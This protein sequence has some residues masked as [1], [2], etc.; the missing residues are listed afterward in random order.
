MV[1]MNRTRDKKVPVH[2]LTGFLGSGKTSLINRLFQAGM[3]DD[4]AVIINE[5]G[6]IGFDSDFIEGNDQEIFEVSGGCLCC[7]AKEG[8]VDAVED[9]LSKGAR[10]V[11]IETSGLAEIAPLLFLLSESD[12]IGEKIRIANV[13]TMIDAVSAEAAIEDFSEA[14]NQVALAD[15][16]VF[17]KLQDVDPSQRG[18]LSARLHSMILARN[19]VAKIDDLQTLIATFWNDEDRFQTTP[20]TSHA[21]PHA[22]HQASLL[23]VTL[24]SRETADIE[25]LEGFLRHLLDRFGNRI[26]RLKGVAELEKGAGV[27]AVHAVSGHAAKFE[28]LVQNNTTGV[29]IVVFYREIRRKEISDLFAAFLDY[30]QTDTPDRDGIV[31]NPLTIPGWHSG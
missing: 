17:T 29:R 10:R 1:D 25:K 4:T 14:R 26:V 27:I 6:E 11:L 7:V 20:T 2:V 5:L 31:D 18:A 15:R 30:P 12:G 23:S 16:V 24:I 3:P 21:H 9:A 28:P 13:T 19:P 8:L 22:T